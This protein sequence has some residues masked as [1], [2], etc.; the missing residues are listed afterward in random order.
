MVFVVVFVV[1]FMMWMERVCPVVRSQSLLYFHSFLGVCLYNVLPIHPFL[2]VDPQSDLIM[3]KLVRSRW[4]IDFFQEPSLLC[5]SR[6]S[7]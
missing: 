6:A 4:P 3:K 5:F 7:N 1:V 2:E